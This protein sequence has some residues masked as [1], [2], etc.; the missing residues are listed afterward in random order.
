LVTLE[1]LKE[2]NPIK[3]AKF[4]V[5][6]H[7]SEEPT[8]KWWVHKVLQ[9]WNRIISKEKLRYWRMTH[10]FGIRLPH[11]IEEALKIDEET[12]TNFWRHAINK[13]SR[14]LGRF[15]R[16]TCQRRPG[17]VR[18]TILLVTKRLAGCHM[19]FNVKMDFTC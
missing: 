4:A 1:E 17:M 2:S 7:L 9:Q 14:L 5:A 8:Y 3:V 10:K 11:S 19:V 16:I 12:G 15:M 6:N 13:E 18:L